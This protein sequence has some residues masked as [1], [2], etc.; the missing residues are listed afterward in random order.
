[1]PWS[2][3]TTEMF[4]DRIGVRQYGSSGLFGGYFGTGVRERAAIS[5]D[6]PA[7]GNMVRG[8]Y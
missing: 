8:V 1:M 2:E 5:A 6:D 3:P 4:S 7:S